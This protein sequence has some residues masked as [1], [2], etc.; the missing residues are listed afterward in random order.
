MKIVKKSEEE[1]I[2]MKKSLIMKLMREKPLIIIYMFVREKEKL[3]SSSP[4]QTHIK[5]TELLSG[6]TMHLT[7]IN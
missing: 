6:V 3:K 5:F 2:Y 7:R 1:E 4:L